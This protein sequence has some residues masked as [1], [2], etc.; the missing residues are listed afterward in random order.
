MSGK[1]DPQRK[2]QAAN[3]RRISFDFSRKY[4]ADVLAKLDSVDN[5]TGYVKQLIRDDIEREK[6]E[7]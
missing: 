2:Y 3:I 6:R 1:Y 7:N 4:D 5:R